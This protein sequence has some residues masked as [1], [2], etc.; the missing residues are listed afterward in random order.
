MKW[1]AAIVGWLFE[2]FGRTAQVADDLKAGL[3][4]VHRANEAVKQVRDDQ[5]AIDED[6]NN[7]DRPFGD[8]H[9]RPR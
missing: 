8:A 7:L 6:P 5:E 9:G 2:R 1:I 4:V 3:D